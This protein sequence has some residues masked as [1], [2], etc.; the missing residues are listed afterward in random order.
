MRTPIS[1]IVALSCYSFVALELGCNVVSANHETERHDG[2]KRLEGGL[3]VVP[4]IWK[5][6]ELRFEIKISED[7]AAIDGW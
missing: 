1:T 3:S 7:R 6:C 5:V 2:A 4:R